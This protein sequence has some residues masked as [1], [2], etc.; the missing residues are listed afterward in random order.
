MKNKF[1][2]NIY[3]GK[4][5]KK[6]R[7]GSPAKPQGNNNSQNA[8]TISGE[9]IVTQQ[10]EYM[11]SEPN[12]SNDTDKPLEY[13]QEDRRSD[14]QREKDR[15]AYLLKK[16]VYS[17][18]KIMEKYGREANRID[19]GDDNDYYEEKDYENIYDLVDD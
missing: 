5:Y 1:Y 6:R 17:L 2:N 8:S 10:Q 13:M 14:S 12:N 3:M 16:S 11:T 18:P 7:G 4:S 9:D 19:E 15:K